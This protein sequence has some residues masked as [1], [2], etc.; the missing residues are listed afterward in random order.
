MLSFVPV[1]VPPE[2]NLADVCFDASIQYTTDTLYELPS[3]DA[4]FS[5]RPRPNKNCKHCRGRG[6]IGRDAKTGKP[7][8][9][10][11]YIK[12]VKRFLSKRRSQD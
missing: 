11:K 10:P 9:C 3:D 5:E 1:K 6:F 7:I 2:I 8:P 12:M 4:L